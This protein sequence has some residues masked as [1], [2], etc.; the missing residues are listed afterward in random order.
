M[1][2]VVVPETPGQ[3]LLTGAEQ[4]AA[5]IAKLFLPDVTLYTGS[6]ATARN[7]LEALTSHTAVHFACHADA[8]GLDLSE[9][10]L[11]ISALSR[12]QLTAPDLAYLSA[13]ETA[14]QDIHLPDENLS[15]AAAFNL[16]GF[17]H[18]IVTL[19]PINDRAAVDIAT[20]TFAQ[21]RAMNASSFLDCSRAAE[22]LNAVLRHSRSAG[23]PASQWCTHIHIGP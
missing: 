6:A 17:G 14:R 20:K 21:L 2:V 19:A 5:A 8:G 10:T 1:L 12:V 7:V 18:I 3:P 22:T 11:T 15:I 4:E 23:Y 9:S 13:C 16:A